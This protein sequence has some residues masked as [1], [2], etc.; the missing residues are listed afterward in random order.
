GDI[1]KNVVETKEQLIER[2][3]YLKVPGQFRKEFGSPK[4]YPNPDAKIEKDGTTT[5]LIF[6][7]DTNDLNKAKR[8]E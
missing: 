2:R 8:G 5:R 6:E 1:M 3:G 7:F 4:H